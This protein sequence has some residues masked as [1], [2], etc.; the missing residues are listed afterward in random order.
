MDDERNGFGQMDWT[1][2]SIYKGLW[3]DGIQSGVGLMI[4]PSNVRKVGLFVNNVFK[5]NLETM[6]EF[7]EE[8]AKCAEAKD[9]KE[10]SSSAFLKVL[11]IYSSSG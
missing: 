7:D 9:S 1:D 2:G 10:S 6:K 8:V 11:L 3:A 5:K 4:F